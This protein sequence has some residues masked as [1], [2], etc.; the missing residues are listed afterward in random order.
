MHQTVKMTSR[1]LDLLS[2]II[3][4]I[5]VEH[6]GHKVKCIL[7]VRDLGVQPREVKPIGQVILVN[8]T[9]ILVTSRRDELKGE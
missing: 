8:L 4:G 3:V 9:E 6:V 1:F 2:E 5:E 7:I